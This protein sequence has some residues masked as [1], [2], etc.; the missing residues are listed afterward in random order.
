MWG[1][2]QRLHVRGEPGQ[3]H[4]HTVVD[5]EHLLE[6]RGQRLLRHTQAQVRAD[7]YAVVPRHRDDGTAVVGHD[8]GSG[9]RGLCLLRC[10]QL[11]VYSKESLVCGVAG[12]ALSRVLRG[13]VKTVRRSSSE[14]D[15]SAPPTGHE[16]VG[17][18]L[19]MV[20]VASRATSLALL[21]L[22]SLLNLATPAA[23]TQGVLAQDDTARVADRW[24][25]W[26]DDARATLQAVVRPR[27]SLS[28][29]IAGWYCGTVPLPRYLLRGLTAVWCSEQLGAR[30]AEGDTAFLAKLGLLEAALGSKDLTALGNLFDQESLALLSASLGSKLACIPTLAVESPTWVDTRMTFGLWQGAQC[31]FGLRF[32]IAC[33]V[34]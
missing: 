11:L 22:L 19:D 7:G 1:N 23:P 26:V 24:R 30:L 25:A 10:A 17:N 3:A 6:V 33:E 31:V 15:G 20:G 9:A 2:V 28:L 14:R 13:R 27:Y 29:G 21:L 12:D 4:V 5:L 34:R 8:C 18:L 32:K 16:V